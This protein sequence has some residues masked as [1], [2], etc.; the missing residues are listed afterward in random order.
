MD[1]KKFLRARN[2]LAAD[3]SSERPRAMTR[4]M[5]RTKRSRR[6]ARSG[7]AT[8]PTRAALQSASA[9]RAGTGKQAAAIE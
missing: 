2:T 5:S 1:A 4:P 6:G 7:S 3:D 9:V 8:T